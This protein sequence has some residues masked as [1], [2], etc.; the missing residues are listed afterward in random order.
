MLWC[1]ALHEPRFVVQSNTF[2]TLTTAR[3]SAQINHLLELYRHIPYEYGLIWSR[4]RFHGEMWQCAFENA[5]LAKTPIFNSSHHENSFTF[6]YSVMKTPRTYFS[7][8]S[9]LSRSNKRWYSGFKIVERFS[10]KLDCSGFIVWLLGS[11]FSMNI[12]N[13]HLLLLW[14]KVHMS[15]F[16]VKLI[17][18]QTESTVVC[19][20]SS[21]TAV[22]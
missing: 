14:S 9:W 16:K 15:I 7:Y 21:C 22:V 18:G 6:R 20:V 17:W 4:T 13:R 1:S 2:L 5:K 19:Y 12:S 8:D 3:A 11:I 10:P